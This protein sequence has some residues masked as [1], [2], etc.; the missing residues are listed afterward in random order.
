MAA[1][2]PDPQIPASSKQNE[3]LKPNTAGDKEALLRRDPVSSESFRQRFRWFCYSEEAGPRK[4]LNQL[5]ALCTQ[6]L[7]PDIHT[8]EQMLELLVFEQFLA[9]LPGEMRIWVKTQHPYNSEEVVTLIEDLTQML[10][11]KEEPVSQESQEENPE[12]EQIDSVLSSTDS[13]GP[14]TLKDVAVNFSRGEWR[15]L[16]PFQKELYKEVL[17]ES[18]TNLE[19]VGFPVSKLDLISQLKCIKL[20]WLLDQDTSESSRPECDPRGNL[21]VLS[22]NEDALLEELTLDNIIEKC[23]RAFDE[24]DSPKQADRLEEDCGNEDFSEVAVTQKKTQKSSHRDKELDSEKA[25]SGKSAK[26]TS[27]ILKHIRDHLRKKSRR[28]NDSKKPFSFHSD[29]VLNHKEY[30]GQKSLKSQEGKKVLSQFSSLS[31]HQKPQKIPLGVKRQKCSNCGIIFAQRLS[32]SQKRHCFRCEKCR[33]YLDQGKALSKNKKTATGEKSHKCSKCGKAFTYNTSSAGKQSHHP[34]EKTDLCDDC[35]KAFNDSSSRT[36]R[37][38]HGGKKLRKCDNCGKSFSVKTDLL[39]HQRIHTGEKPY[40]CK[41]CKRSFN[42]L[43][44]FIQHQRIHTG[45][46]PYKCKDCGKTFTHSSSLCKHQ[47]IHTGEKPYKCDECG[48]TFRQ[49]SCLTRHRR[50]HTGEKPYVC[51][52]G[53]AFSHFSSVIYHRRLHS[54][55]KPYKCEQCEKAFATISL[56]SR[57]ERTHSGVRPY[58][59]KD[60]G[61]VFRQ[62]S[63][64]NEHLRTHTGEKPYECDYCGSTFTRSTILIEHLKTH[65]KTQYK[66]SKCKKVF[67]SSSGLIRHQG[68]HAAE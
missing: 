34:R 16:E 53:M 4:V 35:G 63:S 25:P 1:A 41:E 65:T 52:C 66:C 28:Y 48:K 64:L 14:L 38:S 33:K 21:K 26:Q 36:S 43:S 60:C 59:C 13:Q 5:W 58:E 68:F 56:L 20:P 44:S 22:P 23:L 11:V 8:K 2:S 67:K 29:L 46:R 49:N 31:E 39:K 55:E 62:S 24:S 10:A 42:D 37:S 32:R 9:I 27:V 12:G 30:T 17:L 18:C 45:E 19:S 6:W 40:Q 61:K 3:I 51:D 54:G 47:R 57:H 7:R 15:K 50:I